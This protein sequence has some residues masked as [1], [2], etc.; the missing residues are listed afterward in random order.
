MSEAIY[1]IGFMGAILILIA[2]S[3]ANETVENMTRMD[4]IEQD[5]T[6][7]HASNVVPIDGWRES[8]V[9]VIQADSSTFGGRGSAA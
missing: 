8:H 4:S 6:P 5:E 7:V 3:G 9:S 1:L 2:C